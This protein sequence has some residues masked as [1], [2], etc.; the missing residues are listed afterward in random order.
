MG[1]RKR[2]KL[3][4]KVCF[5][6]I[7]TTGVEGDASII[8]GIGILEEN[9]RFTFIQINKP[10]EEKRKLK[11]AL[12][13]ITKYDIVFTWRGRE[14]DIPFM[15]TRALKH[16]LD[17]SPL[18]ELMHVDLADFTRQHLRLG[19]TD[20]YNVA[21]FFGIQKDTKIQGKDI[22]LTY[23]EGLAKTSRKSWRK[24]REHCRDDLITLM[25]VYEKLKP[26]LRVAK[27]ELAI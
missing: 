25:R 17:P 4:A 16:G 11:Q 12:E 18:Y 23:I 21:R 27:P 5:L 10:E 7:E 19:R 22:P 2:G 14:F 6:D 24:I 1:K 26:L 15:I 20:L 9:R 3:S 8:T 13:I